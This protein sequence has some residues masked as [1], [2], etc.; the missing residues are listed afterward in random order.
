ML[1][2]PQLTAPARSLRVLSSSS[3]PARKPRITC[4][5]AP[6]RICSDSVSSVA[7]ECVLK[8]QQKNVVF[9]VLVGLEEALAGDSKTD[10]FVA[11]KT[12]SGTKKKYIVPIA[13]HRLL[14]REISERKD[15]EGGAAGGGGG[16]G[17]GGLLGR[18][19]RAV[20]N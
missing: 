9:R 8:T 6:D 17:G 15:S 20:L 4:E 18:M 19:S 7:L 16:G 13:L 3:R 12:N 14:S 2:L 10:V 11:K 5:T 1:Y